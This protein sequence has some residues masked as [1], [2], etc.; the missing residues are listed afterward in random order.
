MPR[1]KWQR[2]VARKIGFTRQGSQNGK[3][4]RGGMNRIMQDAVLSGEVL[5]RAAGWLAKIEIE[6]AIEARKI[7]F[8]A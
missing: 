7:T 2:I 4:Q 1:K 8:E 5:L 6:I 3:N